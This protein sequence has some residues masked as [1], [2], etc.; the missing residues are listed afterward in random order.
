MKAMIL[1]AGRGERMR[2]L[3][4]YCPKPLLEVGGK[5]LLAYHLEA[6]GAEGIR[7]VVIN[8]SHLG[9]QIVDW[10]GDGSRWGLQV[11]F[12]R[13]FEPLETAGGLLHAAGLLGEEPFL[14]LNGDVWTD[15]PLS[16]LTARSL[17]ADTLAHL[18]MITNP[19]QHRGG[20]FALDSEGHLQRASK[21]TPSYT[22]AGLG[23][24]RMALLANAM[25]GKQALRPFLDAAID[26]GQL[27]GELYEGAWEDV[28]TPER[29]AA[30]DQRLR[31][32]AA[33]RTE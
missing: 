17:P 7:E 20:D 14:V 6:L 2:P 16:R 12:S 23:I 8:V 19:A 33:I 32:A 1:A 21:Q 27:S 22:Y 24:Y 11:A 30:L 4:D 9:E 10:V 28:G 31:T 25:P 13:E 29:L 15:Y 3:T 18:V 5:P 26:A